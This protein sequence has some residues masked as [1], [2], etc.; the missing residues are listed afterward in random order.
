[1]RY[2]AMPRDNEAIVIVLRTLAGRHR[3]FGYRQLTRMLRRRLGRVNHKWVYRL[4][5]K[6]GLQVPVRRRRRPPR[7]PRQ[8]MTVPRWRNECWSM[9]FVHDRPTT[10]PLRTLSVLDLC[11]RQVPLL[12]AARSMPAERVIRSLE[13][14]AETYGLPKRIVVDNGPE[15]GSRAMQRWAQDLGIEFH[16]IE[17]GKSTQAAFLE[18]FN[19]WLRDEC[20]NERVFKGV[21][22]AQHALEQWRWHYNQERPHRSLGGRTP[23]E[24]AQRLTS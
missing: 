3:R 6:H 15:S 22:E 4:Y 12:T 8:P 14:A 1:M 10:G 24:F 18:S 21:Q 2:Q 23:N 19:A 17:P 20:L 11:T 16:F 7:V 5:R 9:D 13:R